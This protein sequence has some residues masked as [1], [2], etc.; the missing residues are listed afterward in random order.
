MPPISSR[1]WQLRFRAGALARALAC[2][3]ALAGT[4]LWTGCYLLPRPA[5]APIPVLRL[6]PQAAGAPCLVV[7]LP[8]RGDRPEH[9]ERHG[10]D[11][12]AR[13]AGVRCELLAVDAHLGYYRNRSVLERLHQD[14]ILPAR[15]RGVEEIWLV[16]ISLGGVGALLYE[17]EHPGEIAGAVLLAPFLG[18]PPIIEE[19][20]AAGGLAGWQPGPAP[21][22]EEDF[23]RRLWRFLHTRLGPPTPLTATGTGRPAPRLYLGWGED[24]SFAG[25][26][27]LLADALPPAA[28]LTVP[29][30][31]DWPPWRALFAGLLARGALTSGSNSNAGPAP[32][33]RSR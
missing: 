16:G 32:D 12:L 17:A 26:N 21:A 1:T 14:V 18:N 3:S 5:P 7:F 30:G 23:Q 9:F 28:V 6:E 25:A 33:G 8:G 19:V 2:V 10:F 27:R 31:H 29:G 4:G 20:A 15:A 13:E 24:D 11:R 22:G